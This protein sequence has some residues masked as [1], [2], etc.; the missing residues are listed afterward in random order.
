M[1]LCIALDLA[2]MQE[3]LHL[4]NLLKHKDGL[5]VKVGLRSFIRDGKTFLEAIK[6]INAN[7]K[8][9]LD[10]KLYDIPHTM[11]NSIH[12]ITKLGVDMITIHASSGRESM[13]MVMKA[14]REAK[15]PPLAM[16]VTA[17]TSFDEKSFSEVYHTSIQS[18]VLNLSK[19]A[20][21]EGINGVV[22]SCLESLMIKEQIGEEFLTLTPGIRPFE[23]DKGDQKRVANLA[24]A[25]Q[26]KSDFI[27]IGRP[28]YDA[29]NPLEAVDKILKSI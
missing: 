6:T 2:S 29:K 18:Q 17:L 3:N 13:K 5:W 26:A 15:K 19:M 25:K 23:E 8:I 4:L 14:L 11:K 9:F 16:A 24:Q 21:Q 12:E 22:C 27:V 7:F 10:L 1:K 20:A 28:I